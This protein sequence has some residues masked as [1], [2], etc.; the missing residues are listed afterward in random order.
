MHPA[1]QIAKNATDMASFPNKEITDAYND[2]VEALGKDLSESGYI[3]NIE[4]NKAI[5]HLA[6]VVNEYVEEVSTNMKEAIEGAQVDEDEI[7]PVEEVDEDK[8]VIA[9][10]DW[11]KTE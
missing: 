2:F 1:I 7:L 6:N 10:I 4:T 3:E 9:N 8:S 11:D 5:K